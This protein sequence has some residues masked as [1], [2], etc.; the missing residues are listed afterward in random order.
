MYVV[1]AFT[2]RLCHFKN[3]RPETCCSA[4]RSTARESA[5][6]GRGHSAGQVRD[7]AWTRPSEAFS[8]LSP[9][10]RRSQGSLPQHVFGQCGRTE[11][12]KVVLEPLEPLV[13]WLAQLCCRA[14]SRA[15]AQYTWICSCERPVCV[16]T[17]KSFTKRTPARSARPRCSPFSRDGCPRRSGVPGG[18]SPS[19]RRLQRNR[20]TRGRRAG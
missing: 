5:S 1:S 20:W 4:N 2:A 10:S 14:C 19:P 15:C 17:A 13:M 18:G 9:E 7:L 11:S 3:F 12:D 6:P 8:R 16:S